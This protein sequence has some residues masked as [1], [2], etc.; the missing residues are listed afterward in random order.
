MQLDLGG[1][2]KGYAADEVAKTVADSGCNKAL[3]TWAEI[4]CCSGKTTPHG[5]ISATTGYRRTSTGRGA[6]GYKR[7]LHRQA[8]ILPSFLYKIRPAAGQAS[9][10]PAHMSAISHRMAFY[11]TILL[12]RLPDILITAL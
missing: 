5:T 4:L 7:R 1:I 9:S 3:S 12:I 8:R 2:A 10:P 6:S 11:T